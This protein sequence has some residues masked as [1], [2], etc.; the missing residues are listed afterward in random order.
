MVSSVSGL[1]GSERVV[2]WSIIRVEGSIEENHHF[3][4]DSPLWRISYRKNEKDEIKNGRVMLP[5]FPNIFTCS[6]FKKLGFTPT[7]IFGT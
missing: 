4:K 5:K 2:F 6:H 7:W 1:Q 3:G